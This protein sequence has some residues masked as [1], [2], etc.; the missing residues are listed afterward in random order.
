MNVVFLSHVCD[1]KASNGGM[2]YSNQIISQLQR[3]C[4]RVDVLYVYENPPK[5]RRWKIAHAFLR[6]IFA[7]NPAKV[8]YFDRAET[9]RSF[10]E[11]IQAS[12][13]DVV[14]FDHLETVIYMRPV[15]DRVRLVLI[16]HNDEARLY[17]ERLMKIRHPLLAPLLKAECRKLVNFQKY[18]YTKI[19][20]KIFIS[21]DEMKSE[22]ESIDFDNRFCLLPSFDS[23]VSEKCH[24]C[25]HGEPINVAFLGNMDWWPNQDAV[26]WLLEEVFPHVVTDIKLHLIG[27]NS[28]ADRYRRSNVVGHG[29]VRDATAIWEKANI[30]LAP[31]VSGAGLNLKVAEII[32]NRKSIIST[33]RGVRGI[34][35]IGDPAILIKQTAIE[36]ISALNDRRQLDELNRTLPLIQNSSLFERRTS[37]DRLKLFL[38]TCK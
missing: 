25:S 37:S 19:K 23:S 22:T 12:N 30:F 6:S 13:A 1:R 2:V 27:M 16:Q 31:I 4:D 33:P 18:A 38:E 21:L 26:N 11:K 7:R 3:I 10:S 15:L 5:W 20:N 8:I 17:K 36:W 14:I 9:R 34:P 29:F 24:D 32:Y 35:L 28:D